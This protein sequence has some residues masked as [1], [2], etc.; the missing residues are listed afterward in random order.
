MSTWT[1]TE[2][3]NEGE[4]TWETNEYPTTC[5]RDGDDRENEIMEMRARRIVGKW[6][7][8]T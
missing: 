4:L 7:I 5:N 2:I 3:E 8:G 1:T 6:E